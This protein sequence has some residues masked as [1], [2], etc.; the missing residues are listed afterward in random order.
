MFLRRKRLTLVM[1]VVLFIG[2]VG[3]FFAGLK[4]DF[5]SRYHPL[6][7]VNINVSQHLLKQRLK[8]LKKLKRKCVL[9]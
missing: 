8:K 4:V 1:V 7:Y 3:S 6:F 5:Y 9:Q 2:A